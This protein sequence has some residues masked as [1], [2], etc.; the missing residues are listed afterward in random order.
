MLSI[1]KKKLFG[2]TSGTP[3]DIPPHVSAVICLMIEIARLDGKIDENEIEEIKSFYS[4]LYPDGNFSEVFND[5]KDW[6]SHK[7]SFNPFINIINSNC[8]K[9]MKIEIL[10]NI[11]SVILSD[12]NIDPYEESLFMQIGDLLIISKHQ[13]EKIKQ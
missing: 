12:D 13:L 4:D 1:F 3:E 9:K 8:T 11:W 7:E 6:T 10:K 5:L 2:D